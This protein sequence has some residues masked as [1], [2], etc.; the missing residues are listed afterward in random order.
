M[1]DPTQRFGDRVA[2]YIQYRPDYPQALLDWLGEPHDIADLGA[3]TGIFT[4]QLLGRGHRVFAVEPN[5]NMRA[6]IQANP[7]LTVVE[8]TGEATGLPGACVDRV[9]AAQAFHW[10]EPVAARAE[11]QR[12]LRPGG[13]VAI[14][15][16]NRRNDGED[17][18]AYKALLTEHGTDFKLVENKDGVL[19][20]VVTFFAGPFETT[21]FPHHQD[22]DRDGLRGRINSCSYVP[23]KGA[24]G[25]AALMEATDRLFD[26]HAREG[27][28]RLRYDTLVLHGTP[29]GGTPPGVRL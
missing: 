29:P 7:Q 17:M 18:Q 25:W 3:G 15:F 14:V 21:V 8:G 9:V 1:Q 28:F 24:P 2:D 13:R 4:Q 10:F 16:N 12:I 20:R 6:A 11:V 27:V 5:A 22:L 19:Q 26:E 23:A